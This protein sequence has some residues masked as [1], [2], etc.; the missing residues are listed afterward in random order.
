L[1]LLPMNVP[2]Q[3][4]YLMGK[5]HYSD[6]SSREYPI[7]GVR[8]N[9]LGMESY[10]ATMVNQKIPVVL[11]YTP[12][13]DEIVYGATR[14]DKIFVTQPYSIRTIESKGAYNVRLYCFPEWIGEL[15]GYHLRWFLYSSERNARYEVTQHIRYAVN[16]VG[17]QSK[18]YG[19]NQLLNVN[20]TLS[21]INPLYENFRYAQTVQVVLWRAGDERDTNWTVV[22]ENGQS[23]AYG[24]T[25]HGRLEFINY[26]Y[27]KLNLAS[28]CVSQLEWLNKLY[29]PMKPIYDPLREAVA[30]KPSHFRV[31]VG[32]S[33]VLEKPISQW[34]LTFSI[35]NGLVVSGNVYIEWILK[36]PE[37]DLELGTSGMILWDSGGVPL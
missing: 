35:L 31:R 5:V 33:E 8:F 11:R 6:G 20:L 22:Y 23:P 18:A 36:T 4:L 27:Y 16:T 30:P 1:I 21:D 28:E 19:I 7:D 3:G 12:T 25:T 2:L 37:T 9:L 26:N 34:N 32:N 10:L 14:G 13:P 24:D 15:N 29:Y 17:F